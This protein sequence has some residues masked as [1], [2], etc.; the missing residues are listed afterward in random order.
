MLESRNLRT[1]HSDRT[2][3][4]SVRLAGQTVAADLREVEREERGDRLGGELGAVE[5][6]VAIARLSGA[7]AGMPVSLTRSALS[8]MRGRT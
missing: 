1:F 3:S 7:F 8:G 4:N 5:R 6:D 2:V